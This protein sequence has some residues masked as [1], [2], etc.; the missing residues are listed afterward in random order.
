YARGSNQPWMTVVGVVADVKANGLDQPDD[1]TIY[2][3]IFQKQEA[4][5]RW[6]TIVIRSA[7]TSPMK[8]APAM[9]KQVWNLDAQLPVVRVQPLTWYLEGSLAERRFNTLLLGILATMALALAM[10]GIY[11]VISYTVSLRTREFGVRMALGAVRS[12]LMRVVFGGAL[13]MVGVGAV[14]WLL[15]AAGITRLLSSLLYHV[16]SRDPLT[17]IAITLLLFGV[18]LIATYIPAH[19]ATK[20]E[21]MVALR[22]E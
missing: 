22:Y 18:A 8:L 1:P 20:I 12:D 21:P 11:G 3:P 16:S 15:A 10:V 19:R 6:A 2:T 9:K 14:I 5:R 4:W 7:G 13:R 17:F